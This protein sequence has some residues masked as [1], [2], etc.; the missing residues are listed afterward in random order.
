M[1]TI[2]TDAHQ[3]CTPNKHVP[4]VIVCNVFF[5]S[6]RIVSLHAV[7]LHIYLLFVFIIYLVYIITLL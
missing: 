4:L 3:T 1:D 7:L 6:L 2:W 5:F